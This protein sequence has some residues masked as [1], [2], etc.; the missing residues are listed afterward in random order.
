MLAPAEKLQTIR[1]ALPKEGLF[2][3]KD[4]LVSPDP[5]PVSEK[6][7]REL[8]QLGHRLSVF[9]RACNQLYQLS[10][11]GKQPPWIAKYLDAGKPPQLVE[12]A[13]QK[14]FRELLPRIIRPDLILTETGYIIAEIDSVPGGIGLTAW[15]NRTYA[16]LGEDVIGGERGMLDGFRTVLP[17]G[18]DIV[19]SEESATYR[20]EMG[21]LVQEM[22][23]L[24]PERN[25]QALAA[26]NYEPQDGRDVY[27]FFELF[28]LANIPGMD[29]L[30]R[31]AADERVNV[32]APLKP[33]LEEKLSF[34]LCLLQPVRAFWQ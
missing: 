14:Q 32:T 17:N 8:E 18:G 20:P 7:A 23:T 29:S 10:V 24:F 5:F 33:S 16:S 13:R 12:Y 4:W 25:W 3:D 27:R 21:W 1:N 2:A 31:A 11:R 26:E 30:L 28:D 22:N 6:F 15:L 19:V 34:A 9:Q